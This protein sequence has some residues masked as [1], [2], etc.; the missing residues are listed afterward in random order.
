MATT[1]LVK[2][3]ID[4]ENERINLGRDLV[5]KLD[6]TS[7]EVR[8]AFWFYFPEN[9]EW[10]LILSSPFEAKYGPK[11]SYEFLSNLLIREG[12]GIPLQNIS[13]LSQSNPLIVNLRFFTRTDRSICGISISD[14]YIN[15]FHIDEAFIYRMM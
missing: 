12:I 9:K 11:K 2:P 3:L 4:N 5:L 6:E 10:R 14:C 13:V 7:F 1:T 8:S 15:N